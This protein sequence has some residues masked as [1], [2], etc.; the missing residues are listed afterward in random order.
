M[1]IKQ[2]KTA[3]IPPIKQFCK[4]LLIAGDQTG[5]R[6]NEPHATYKITTSY[7]KGV[8]QAEEVEILEGETY[9]LR[10][11]ESYRTVISF[12]AYAMDEDIS[13][14]LAQ[15]IY[16]WFAFAG[17]DVLQSAGV[18]VIEQTDVTNRDAFI[19]NGYERRNGFDVI[20][21]VPRVT[22]KEI[23][24]IDTVNLDNN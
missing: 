8:G 13:V 15:S 11:T 6:P 2:L 18:S 9:K 12:T 22:D 5:P 16:D 10:R 3:I 4:T 20:L 1:N 19:I 17:L 24:W 14:D 21:R 7:G 23:E